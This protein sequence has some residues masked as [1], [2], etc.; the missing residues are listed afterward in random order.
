MRTVTAFFLC[1]YYATYSA[2]SLA[3]PFW[4]NSEANQIN[5][6]TTFKISSILT[7]TDDL[8]FVSNLGNLLSIKLLKVELD[9]GIAEKYR[10]FVPQINPICKC[11][12]SKKERNTENFECFPKIDDNNKNHSGFVTKSEW[13]ENGCLTC[14]VAKIVATPKDF[15]AIHLSQ[16]KP[17]IVATFQ[18]NTTTT[19]TGYCKSDIF[20]F[21]NQVKT[22]SSACYRDLS[23]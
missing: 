16:N 6:N 15:Y 2:R 20:H 11:S 10:F 14:C 19:T 3:L 18:I 1:L 22:V 5:N 12:C 13:S 9:Y 7:A 23:S 4:H 21:C 8:N 17:Q